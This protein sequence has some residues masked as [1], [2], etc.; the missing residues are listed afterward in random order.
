LMKFRENRKF[1]KRKSYIQTEQEREKL[2]EE[3]QEIL[4]KRE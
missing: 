2:I 4:R 1:K 3:M